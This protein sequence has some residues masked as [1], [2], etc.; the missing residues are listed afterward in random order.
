MVAAFAALAALAG[1]P[2]AGAA[3]AVVS[4]NDTADFS[5]ADHPELCG[6]AKGP[7]ERLCTLR[8][9][10]EA[11]HSFDG[12]PAGA[13]SV[14]VSLP[15]GHYALESA[16]PLPVGDELAEACRGGGGTAGLCPLTLQGAGAGASVID[17]AGATGLLTVAKGAG[18]IT[19][20]GVTL[21][22]SSAAGGAIEDEEGAPLL[23]RDS[24]LQGNAGGAVRLER[25]AMTISGSA[26]QGNGG[27]AHLSAGSLTLERSS[28]TGTTAAAA[29]DAT[30]GANLALVDTTVAANE[31]GAALAAGAGASL[32]VRWSTIDGG[33]GTAVR[34]TGAESISLEGAILTGAAA[35]ACQGQETVATPGANVL[36]GGGSG[37]TVAGIAPSGADPLLGAPTQSGLVTVLPLL[38]GSP[39]LNAGSASCPGS[40]VEGVALDERGMAR[41]QGAGCD[42]GAFESGADASLS[43]AARPAT[44]GAAFALSATVRAA[45][46]DALSGVSVTIPLP[47]LANLIAAPSGCSATYGTGTLVTCSLGA[48]ASGA[49]RT[50]TLQVQPLAVETLALAAGVQA[51]QAD[52]APGDDSASLSLAVASPAPGR[53]FAA[54]LSRTLRVNRH[55]N[56]LVRMRCV[57]SGAGTPCATSVALY[58]PHGAIAGRAAPPARRLAGASTIF[59]A[60]RT[61]TVLIHLSKRSLASIHLRRS[62]SAR[63][64]LA[65]GAAPVRRSLVLVKLVRTR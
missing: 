32:D 63:L 45:G 43:L 33:A 54:L 56:A 14:V 42:L 50:V 7:L 20:A 19:V 41:P 44:A 48:L 25:A 64:V 61:V 23:V 55:G 27:A 6:R 62:A 57:A 22:G 37:C 5:L 1:A 15:A 18:P 36:H 13:E 35:L 4:V 26:L 40:A 31:A 17:A 9:A 53:P 65:T 12:I 24:V 58:G 38:R 21:T 34:A 52:Y 29:I 10:L 2:A 51:E 59:G 49:T 28:V 8:A 46:A 11:A 47:E 16:R 30:E 60:G 39:A 3:P